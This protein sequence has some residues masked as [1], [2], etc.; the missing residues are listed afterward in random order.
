M[1]NRPWNWLIDMTT[2]T[3]KRANAIA[4]ELY[5]IQCWIT[6]CKNALAD[7]DNYRN[8]P[9]ITFWGKDSFLFGHT[10]GAGGGEVISL[11]PLTSKDL[12]EA[13]ISKLTQ[14]EEEL[15]KQLEAI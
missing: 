7:T 15:A 10:A 14:Q 12:L 6:S 11:L 1:L 13:A 5:K 9:S 4:A 8:V 3:L 2:E